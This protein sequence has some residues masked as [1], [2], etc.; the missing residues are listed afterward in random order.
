MDRGVKLALIEP[1]EIK[2]PAVGKATRSATD[3]LEFYEGWHY[4]KD[5]CIN[6]TRI[7][8]VY[9]F[10]ENIF[11]VMKEGDATLHGWYRADKTVDHSFGLWCFYP[12]EL[13]KE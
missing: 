7:F 13:E 4:L 3:S 6:T 11:A 1:H 8:V 12:R 2:S 9:S 5:E 10:V